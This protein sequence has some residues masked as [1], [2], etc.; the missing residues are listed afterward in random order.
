MDTVTANSAAFIKVPVGMVM[1]YIGPE[2]QL[3]GLEERGWLRC[4]GQSVNVSGHGALYAVLGNSCGGDTTNFN[5]PDLR[6]MFLRGVDAGAKVD[7]DADKRTAQKGGRNAGNM[8][9]SRQADEFRIHNHL[10][11]L[12]GPGSFMTTHHQDNWV[13][14]SNRVDYNTSEVGGNETRPKNVYVYYLIFAGF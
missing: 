5:L 4:N 14:P 6:G 1:P 11:N 12:W 3:N 9:A 10:L 13:P 7:P 8:V 2:G